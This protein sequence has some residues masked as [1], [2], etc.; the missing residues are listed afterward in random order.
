MV[1]EN[2]TALKE[3]FEKL[4]E[5]KKKVSELKAPS[6][7]LGIYNSCKRRQRVTWSES[8][9][10]EDVFLMAVWLMEHT[11][12]L[13]GALLAK[14]GSTAVKHLGKVIISR[15]LFF[16]SPTT[17]LPPCFHLSSPCGLLVLEDAEEKGTW[18]KQ[19]CVSVSAAACPAQWAKK[20]PN[21][22]RDDQIWEVIQNLQLKLMVCQ[23]WWC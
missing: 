15:F 20:K 6:K 9:M 17:T 3:Q 22:W 23:F 10:L 14:S 19:K 12:V 11:W 4:V 8:R 5:W 7:E 16:L 1:L 13:Q 2:L 21:K 18:G